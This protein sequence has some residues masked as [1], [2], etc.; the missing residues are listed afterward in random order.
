MKTI[1]ILILLFLAGCNTGCGTLAETSI[2]Q[3]D[4]SKLLFKSK[5]SKKDCTFTYIESC[6]G[7]VCTKTIKRTYQR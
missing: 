4:K 3:C 5:K 1:M 7:N 6:K 2:Y